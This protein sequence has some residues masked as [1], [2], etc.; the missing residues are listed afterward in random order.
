MSISWGQNYPVEG[1]ALT[2]WPVALTVGSQ[3]ISK[4]LQVHTIRSRIA[5][6]LRVM[7]I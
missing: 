3:T 1:V 2:P 4:Y 5:C 6:P 7:I